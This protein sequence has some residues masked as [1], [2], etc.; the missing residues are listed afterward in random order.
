MKG[1]NLMAV[2][3]KSATK[4]KKP[5]KPAKKTGGKKKGC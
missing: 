3:K 2:V 5:V 4:A 1:E